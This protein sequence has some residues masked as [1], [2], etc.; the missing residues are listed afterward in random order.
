[1]MLLWCPQFQTFYEYFMQTDSVEIL[2]YN[3]SFQ[4]SCFLLFIVDCN[5]SDNH[6]KVQNV[7]LFLWLNCFVP[8]LL[9]F[10]THCYYRCGSKRLFCW[11][12]SLLKV[13]HRH[14]PLYSYTPLL[15]RSHFSIQ[16]YRRDRSMPGR[17]KLL[18]YC[19]STALH[20]GLFH[21][22]CWCE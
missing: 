8:Y 11:S 1:M 13:S 2:I 16:A 10:F 22:D 20:G 14:V 4:S 21:L 12:R 6:K 7:L 9:Y 17:A 15:G 18:T 3:S 5:I 19:V